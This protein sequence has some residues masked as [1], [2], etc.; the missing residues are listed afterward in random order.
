MN[1]NQILCVAVTLIVARLFSSEASAAEISI[2]PVVAAFYD[3]ITFVPHPAIPL[4][5]NPGH[6]VVVQVDVTMQVLSLAPGEDSFGLAG[7]SFDLSGNSPGELV[8]DPDVGGWSGNFLPLEPHPQLPGIASAFALNTDEGI[9]D[10]DLKNILVQMVTVAL[11]DAEDPRRNIGETGS[12]WGSPVVVGSAYLK[13][14]GVGEVRFTLDSVQ[15]AAKLTNGQFVPGTAASVA[16]ITLGS[17]VPEPSS[18]VMMAGML[19][20]VG[21]RRRSI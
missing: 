11:A 10:M 1:R 4:G 13:W 19:V 6:P 16:T 2:Q 9:S 20:G 5:T 7:F 21:L 17:D 14:S 18:M 3:P 12:K 15:V 8:P